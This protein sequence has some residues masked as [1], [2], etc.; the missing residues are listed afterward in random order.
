VVYKVLHFLSDFKRP[1]SR[2]S[3]TTARNKEKMFKD[4]NQLGLHENELI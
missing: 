4:A 1:E 3:K 2:D